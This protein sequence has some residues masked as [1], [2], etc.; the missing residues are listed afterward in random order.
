MKPIRRLPMIKPWAWV[1]GLLLG[2]LLNATTAHAQ[3]L[4]RNP[5]DQPRAE[6]LYQQA[7][8]Q[9]GTDQAVQWLQQSIE[10]CPGIF[11]SRYALAKTLLQLKRYPEAEAAANQ[12]IAAADPKDWDKRLAGWVLV[13]EAQRGQNRWGEA[14]ATFDANVRALLQPPKE[15]ARIAP[16]WF[17]EAYAAFEDALVKRG[18]LKAGEIAGVFRSAKST[19]AV[20]RIALRVEFDYDKATLT[21]QGQAQ[22]QEVAKAIADESVREYAFQVSGHTDQRGTPEYN[23]RLSERRA[24][25]VV[26]ELARLQPGLGSRLHPEGKAATEPRIANA[27][28]EAQ[29][30][31]NRRVEF[32]AK[33]TP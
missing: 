28:D 9:P 6:E 21:T 12:A 14:K 15:P 10:L 2:G 1:S 18:G 26:T 20:P 4:C 31:V 16:A 19:G 25:A 27:A 17:N 22:V 7:L 8:Q 11:Q 30:A 3:T 5:S 29:H 24:Q 23:Q 33:Q 13:A 32:E